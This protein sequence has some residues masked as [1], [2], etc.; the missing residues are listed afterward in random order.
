MGNFKITSLPK[1]QDCGFVETFEK[2]QNSSFLFSRLVVL[3]MLA[4]TNRYVCGKGESRMMR[5]YVKVYC[6]NQY[7]VLS[8]LAIHPHQY[9]HS[10][11]SIL[12]SIIIQLRPSREGVTIWL[13][14]HWVAPRAGGGGEGGLEYDLR[15]WTFYIFS[16]FFS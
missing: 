13:G 11:L 6:P 4:S 10:N 14:P 5:R 9:R 3:S 15:P 7:Y 1:F 12:Y 2:F 16:Y 8:Y